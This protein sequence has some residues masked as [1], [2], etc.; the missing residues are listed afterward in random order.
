[1]NETWFFDDVK[2]IDKTALEKA[3]HKQASL[4]KPPGSLGVLEQVAIAFSG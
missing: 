2:A 3:V 4:T 1:M